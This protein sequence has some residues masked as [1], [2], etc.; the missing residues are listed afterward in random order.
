MTEQTTVIPPPAVV[1]TS[2]AAP[3]T[4]GFAPQADTHPVGT[5]TLGRQNANDSDKSNYFESS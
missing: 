3:R 5:F 1:D 4:G 2:G